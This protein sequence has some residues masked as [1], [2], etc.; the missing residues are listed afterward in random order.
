MGGPMRSNAKTP[1]A[2][3][4]E[5]FSFVVPT[6]FAELPSNGKY[7]PEDHPLHNQQVIEFKHMTAKEEDILT[8][9]TLLKKGIAIDRVIQNVIVDKSIDPD[10]LLV[11]DRNALIIALR[12][13]SYG[14]DYETG[15]AC[16]SCSSKVQYSFDLEAANTYSGEDI[17]DMDIANN[18]DGTFEVIL[19]ATKLTIVFKL[20]NGR[21]EKNYLK[22]IDT[23]NK[24]KGT[25]RVVSQQLMAIMVSINSDSR[26]ETR[27]YVS[28][29][30]PSKDSR[31]LRAAYKLANPN[32]NL[33]QT[34]VC[35]SCGYEAD[36]EVP[37]SA[38]FFWPDK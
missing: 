2:P 32:V 13:A 19:P 24:N 14:N 12:G 20:L 31:Y 29:N 8:S 33:T 37:L 18:D 3:Q 25:E 26:I 6:D 17:S 21:E 16:P 38:D 22:S 30:L 28:E 10:S 36:M 9:K 4:P 34:F 23:G 11:G 5:G 27:R 7:Y 1:K 15:V 35:S